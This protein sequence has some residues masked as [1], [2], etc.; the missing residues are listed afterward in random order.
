MPAQAAAIPPIK[1]DCSPTGRISASPIIDLPDQHPGNATGEEQGQI[2]RPVVGLRP[3][4]P[5]G[6][7]ATIAMM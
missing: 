2:A 7:I 6:E 5:D 4:L 1:P 3:G